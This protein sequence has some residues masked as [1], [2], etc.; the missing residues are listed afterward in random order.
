LWGISQPDYLRRADVWP[1]NPE[2]ELFAMIMIETAEGARNI[3]EIV[4]V[5][6]IGAI[7]VGAS[8]LGMS[9]GVGPASPLPPPETE[10]AIQQI[11]NACRASK[12][13][14]AYPVLGGETELKRRL[15][16]G[17]KVLLVAGGPGRSGRQGQ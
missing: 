14:C 4:K 6:G 7:F 1:L 17:F 3:N 15:D 10:A 12:V 11:A 2:G 9:L 5:P 16:Q 8:D 13:T